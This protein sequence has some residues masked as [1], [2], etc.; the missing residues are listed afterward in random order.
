MYA[1]T[2]A[3]IEPI[4]GSRP[5][6]S[7]KGSFGHVL[8]VGG[9]LGKSGAAA[10]SGMAALRAGTGLVTVATPVGVL[11]SVA[12]FAP[13]LPTEPLPET[14]S[15]SIGVDALGRLEYMEENKSV[16]AFGPWVARDPESA[17]FVRMPGAKGRHAV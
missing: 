7:H 13:E 2:A 17:K 16:G 15:G 11:Q 3:D 6:L 8:V 1:I 4:V 14:S 9:S 5:L 12:G 10:M